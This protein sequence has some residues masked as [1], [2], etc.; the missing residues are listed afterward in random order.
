MKEVSRVTGRRVRV[1]GDDFHVS[2]D[3]EIVGPFTDM[4]WE[5]RPR[6]MR[7]FLPR[8]AAGSAE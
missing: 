1:A 8:S 2:G 4:Q 7:M 6:A 5:L 3:G